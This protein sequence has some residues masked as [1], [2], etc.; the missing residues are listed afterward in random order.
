MYIIQSREDL[1]NTSY[2]NVQRTCNVE[3]I[4][5]VEQKLKSKNNLWLISYIR[6]NLHNYLTTKTE[7]PPYW[8]EYTLIW[9]IFFRYFIYMYI[10]CANARAE[11]ITQIQLK[12]ISLKFNGLVLL[13]DWWIKEENN[14][15]T[16]NAIV[17]LIHAYFHEN[18]A[19]YSVRMTLTHV[20]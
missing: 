12:N 15:R 7:P 5:T 16:T 11:H 2:W 1:P 19:W 6:L 14:I 4:G 10:L 3:H 20:I 18:W 13:W 8:D 9:T 17:L